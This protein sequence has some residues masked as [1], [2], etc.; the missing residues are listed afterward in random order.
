MERDR[1][2]RTEGGG[3]E[4]ETERESWKEMKW[5]SHINFLFSFF[6]VSLS[7]SMKCKC[8]QTELQRGP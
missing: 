6:S 4:R 3:Y 5:S 7:L 8:K 1:A 2:K